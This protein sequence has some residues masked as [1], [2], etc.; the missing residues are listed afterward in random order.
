M[1]V[2]KHEIYAI[3]SSRRKS[4]IIAAVIETL[5]SRKLL[6]GISFNAV[7]NYTLA[8]PGS[9]SS[10]GGPTAFA[11]F[12]HDGHI[13]AAAVVNDTLNIAYGNADGTFTVPKSTPI[14]SNVASTFV[15]TANV[16]GDG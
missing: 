2:W 12:N 10:S 7:T 14:A 4:R 15:A 11:D 1:S 9:G 3:D 16:S 8:N 6:S 13:D 5:E